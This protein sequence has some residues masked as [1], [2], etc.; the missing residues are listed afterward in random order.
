MTLFEP[1]SQPGSVERPEGVPLATE[2]LAIERML[3][4]AI[5]FDDPWAYLEDARDRVHL[6]AQVWSDRLKGR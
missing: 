5:A 1:P 3:S 4:A 6:L 2:L